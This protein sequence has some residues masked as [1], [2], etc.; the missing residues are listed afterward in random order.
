MCGQEP[1][2]VSQASEEL[3]PYDSVR[4]PTRSKR[5]CLRCST[6]SSLHRELQQHY[7]GGAFQAA[8][9][10]TEHRPIWADASS[11]GLNGVSE[12]T[13][14]RTGGNVHGLLLMELRARCGW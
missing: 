10:S 6:S 14:S 5:R 3:L 8:L 12:T 2:I 13:I 11:F 9:L 4:T 1:I 7:A